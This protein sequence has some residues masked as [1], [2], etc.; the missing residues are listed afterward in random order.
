MYPASH[1]NALSSCQHT[2]PIHLQLVCHSSANVWPDPR[3]DH[4][5]GLISPTAAGLSDAH[6]S[7][8]ATRLMLRVP[9][10]ALP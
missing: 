8:V 3:G 1:I 7:T 5:H 9:T 6:M 4:G 10:G 2:Y